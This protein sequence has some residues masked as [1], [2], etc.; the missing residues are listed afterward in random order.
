M[1]GHE[2]VTDDIRERASMYALGMLEPLES[3]AFEQHLAACNVCQDEVRAYQ[4]VAVELAFSLPE[5][6]PGPLVREQL[7][8]RISC[9]PVLIRKGK[10]IWQATPFPG[11]EVKQ[12]F[13][14]TATGNVTS[15]VRMSS[16]AKYPAH[17]HAGHEQCYV[18]EG[19]LAFSD[20][21]L[22]A[23]DYE[24]S[25]PAT[26]HTPVTTH[27]GCLLLLTNNQADQ[28]FV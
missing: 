14:D 18:L 3:E 26:D 10:G 8:S 6:R 11:V 25:A 16:G 13:V 12:L 15:L 4:T 19:D 28:V 7:L 20:H 5:S 17:R 27:T 23:G 22:Y 1:N 24:V 2:S 9:P 21:T